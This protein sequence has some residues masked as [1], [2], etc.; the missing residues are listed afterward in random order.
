MET[1]KKFSRHYKESVLVKAKPESVFE[2]ADNPMNFSSHMNQPSGMMAGGS[3]KTEV[4]EGRGKE[5]GSHIRMNGNV[6]GVNLSLDEVI[7][8][9]QPPLRKAWETVGNVNLLVIDQY[10]LGFEIKPVDEE[11]ELTVYINYDLPKSLKTQLLGQIFSGTYAK[12]CVQQ[13]TTGAKKH[14]E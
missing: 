12:W 4:D 8:E 11:S 2:Y 10:K 9:H 1:N 14:F 7:V 3:M 13:M 5:V 6:L